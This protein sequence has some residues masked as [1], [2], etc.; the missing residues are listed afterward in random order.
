MFQADMVL[1][2]CRTVFLAAT[3]LWSVDAAAQPE[4]AGAKDFPLIKRY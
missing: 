3:L 1:R 2:R 4:V